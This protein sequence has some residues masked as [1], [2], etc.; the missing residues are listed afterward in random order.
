MIG[1]T[2]SNMECFL[3]C[4]MVSNI[5]F[6]FSRDSG[7]ESCACCYFPLSGSVLNGSK[8]EFFLE[9]SSPSQYKEY[10]H[11]DVTICLGYSESSM[12]YHATATFCQT[13]GGDLVKVDSPDKFT[14]LKEF[15]KDTAALTKAKVWVQGEE[16]NGVWQFHDGIPFVDNF[17]PLSE[18]NHIGEN[19]MML[20]PHSNFSCSDMLADRSY[21]FVCEISFRFPSQ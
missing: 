5:R 15:I 13:E 9:V 21:N 14:I 18:S 10:K 17:C 16:V 20:V 6:L 11:D 19:H 2:H 1:T 12:I 4:T 7:T 8:W 3:Q